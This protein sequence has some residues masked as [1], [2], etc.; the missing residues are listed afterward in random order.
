MGKYSRLGKNAFLMFLGNM[1]SK[2]L[3][4]L[5]LPFYTSQLSVGDYGTMDLVQVYVTL[6]TSLTTCCLTEAIFVFPKSQLLIKQKSYF[7]SGLLFSLGTLSLTGLLFIL[8]ISI[9]RWLSYDGIFVEYNLYIFLIIC[10]TFFQSYV[11]QFVRSIDKVKVYVVSGVVLT[12]TT[13]LSSLIF[14]PLWG[15]DGYIY[16]M[17]L[18]YFVAAIYTVIAGKEYSYFSLGLLSKKQLK[19]ML[20]YSIPMIPNSIMWWVLSTL[21]RPLLEYYSGIDSVGIL[22]VANK[23]PMIIAMVYSVFTYSWQISVLEEFK[24][25]S[26]KFFYN[27]IFRLLFLILICFLLGIT[28]LGRPLVKLMTTSGY[29]E[30][31]KYVSVLSLAVVFSNLSGFV[32]TNFLATKESKYYFSTSVWG[33]TVCLISNFL[34]IPL[35]GIWGAVISILISNILM[36]SLRVKIT[37]KYAPIFD[38]CSYMIIFLIVVIYIFV[39]IFVSD[40][41]LDIFCVCILLCV[42]LRLNRKLLHEVF[43]LGKNMLKIK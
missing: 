34:L 1:G 43:L 5:M 11:Q 40:I 6:L 23:F 2:I 33:G 35:L 12:L 13:V 27:K 41:F 37:W 10:V 8:L 16:S 31:W 30:A 25:I 38:W 18:S 24:D 20:K 29:N 21:N 22:A 7:T 42:I 3:T 19:E 32:G 9:L 28:I 14:L 4:F 39:N 15:I 17:I 36:F 26:Y